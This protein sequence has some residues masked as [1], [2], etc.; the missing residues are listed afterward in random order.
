[1]IRQDKFAVG[2]KVTWF[3]DDYAILT[4]GRKEHGDGPF[5]IM[6]IHDVQSHYAAVGHTQWVQPDFDTEC[7]WSGAYFKKV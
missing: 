2:D 3:N 6:A 4:Q 1:M 5:T 7:H